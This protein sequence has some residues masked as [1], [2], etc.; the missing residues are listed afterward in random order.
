MEQNIW[1][2]FPVPAFTGF[3]VPVNLDLQTIDKFVENGNSP[4]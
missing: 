2:V 4:C 3:Q 1:C